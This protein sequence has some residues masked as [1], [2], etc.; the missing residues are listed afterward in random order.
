MKRLP[1]I[2]A[3]LLST[4]ALAEEVYYCV[5]DDSTGFINN[6]KTGRQERSRFEGNKL[7][8]KLLDD[9]N[10]LVHDHFIGKQLFNC[11]KPF[12]GR[13]DSIS[14]EKSFHKSCTLESHI[15]YM[16]NFNSSNGRFVYMR[17][18]GYVFNNDGAYVSIGTCTAF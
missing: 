10:V 12:D 8:M 2:L 5:E 6:E 11:Y 15:G 1:I 3:M 9:G 7:K 18:S 17:G 16:F 13:L 4:T 14:P